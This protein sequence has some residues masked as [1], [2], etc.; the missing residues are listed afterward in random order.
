MARTIQTPKTV[1]AFL[2]VDVRP[3]KEIRFRSCDILKIEPF[4]TI[5]F[6]IF[7][8]VDVAGA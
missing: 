2:V 5:D 8:D 1:Y 4:K 3:F 7:G 6:A